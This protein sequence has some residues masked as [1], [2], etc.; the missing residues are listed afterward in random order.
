MGQSSSAN[1]EKTRE[2]P[3]P[4]EATLY[5]FAGRGIADQI[6]WMLAATNVTFVQ[7]TV[8]TR[9]RFLKMAERQLPFGQLPLLQIDGLELV[10]SQSI[11]RYLA[12]RGHLVGQ[13]LSEETKC[14]MIAECIRGMNYLV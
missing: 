3:A 7:K 11:V 10:Q 13:N 12:R 8:E 5:Y 2:K 4:C 9:Q 1:Y 14:D 6:R